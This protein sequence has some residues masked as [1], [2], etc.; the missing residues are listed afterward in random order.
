MSLNK[1]NF[2]DFKAIVTNFEQ[3]PEGQE[4]DA[5][6]YMLGKSKVIYRKAHITPNK[7]GQFVTQNGPK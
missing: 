7:A 2:R 6:T 3:S 4:Y 5:C 1:I